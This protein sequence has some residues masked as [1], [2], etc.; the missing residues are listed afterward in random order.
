M[1]LMLKGWTVN[2]I[3]QLLQSYS[4]EIDCLYI[5]FE[6]SFYDFSNSFAQYGSSEVT[7]ISISA[8]LMLPALKAAFKMTKVIYYNMNNP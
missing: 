8:E 3:K 7:Y 4:A 6:T 1:R 5:I 2:Y